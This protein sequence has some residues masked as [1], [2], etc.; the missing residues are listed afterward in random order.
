MLM[1]D[2]VKYRHLVINYYLN[3]FKIIILKINK[4]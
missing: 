4:Y 1:H 2:G 3:Y